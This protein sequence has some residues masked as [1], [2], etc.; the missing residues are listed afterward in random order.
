MYAPGNAGIILMEIGTSY[1][2]FAAV[3]EF[4]ITHNYTE[5][6]TARKPMDRR[7]PAQVSGRGTITPGRATMRFDPVDKGGP[8][9]RAFKD[10]AAAGR[11]VKLQAWL[12]DAT[13]LG[14][15]VDG[16]NVVEVAISQTGIMTLSEKGTGSTVIASTFGSSDLLPGDFW[17]EGQYIVI[18]DVAYHIG[19]FLT[20]TTRKISRVGAV[21]ASGIV[22]PDSV[23]LTAVPAEGE[24]KVYGYIERITFSGQ[25]TTTG[26]LAASA[27][28]FT[29]SLGVDLRSFES[30]DF[31]VENYS[32][33]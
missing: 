32:V 25:P 28:G 21:D 11:D 26:D 30:Q 15:S 24:Y 29:L 12:G 20:S 10:A 31:S 33:S 3:S 14:T 13:L 4:D 1:Q 19:P 18:S 7:V 23:A 2:P 8:V 5:P 22:T 9:F 6:E 17:E 27:D 16:A